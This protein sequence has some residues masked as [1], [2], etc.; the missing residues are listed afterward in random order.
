MTKFVVTTGGDAHR[1][2]AELETREQA[3]EVAGR[4][5]RIL[6]EAACILTV[7][8]ARAFGVRNSRGELV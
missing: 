4:C 7:E 6:R 3:L 8:Q 2:L 1:L 5:E